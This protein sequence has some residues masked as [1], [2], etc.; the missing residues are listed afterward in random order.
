VFGT[1]P[2]KEA[3]KGLKE[4]HQGLRSTCRDDHFLRIADVR[5]QPCDPFAS[6]AIKWAPKFDPKLM[7]SSLFISGKNLLAVVC[8]GVGRI[9]F[10]G[11]NSRFFQ[12]ANTP[13]KL[14]VK[15]GPPLAGI[16]TFKV[17]VFCVFQGVFV[18]SAGI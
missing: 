8:M 3:L 12:G 7:Q 2:A 18:F 5:H 13:A 14:N 16:L 9:F 10:H 4:D 15:T 17:V 6:I 1:V 11:G